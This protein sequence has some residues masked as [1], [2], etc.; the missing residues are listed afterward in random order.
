MLRSKA[1]ELGMTIVGY[2]QIPDTQAAI[3]AT[4]QELD[5]QGVDLI[6]FGATTNNGILPLIQTIAAR[7]M[8]VS[9][10]G[11]D[12]IMEQAFIDRG[13]A[14]AEGTYV[15]V[16]GMPASEL[17]GSGAVFYD[18]YTNRFGI[19]PETFSAFGYEAAQVALLAIE[20]AGVKDRTQI[21]KELAK[22]QD[23]TGLFGTWSFDRNG[24]TSL[25]LVSGNRVQDGAFTFIDLLVA[26]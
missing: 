25:S 14:A 5:A 11:P 1:H 13:G 24:D 4:L 20:R 15:T 6:Y 12:G 22:I 16:A 7:D 9:V 10:M 8:Q 2:T 19:A 17:T 18:A 3:E 26:K 21:I 23:Y